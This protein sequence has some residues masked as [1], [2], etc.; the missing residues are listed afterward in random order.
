ME[1]TF[2]EWE[3]SFNCRFCGEVNGVEGTY[4]ICGPMCQP[5]LALNSEGNVLYPVEGGG[6]FIIFP[7]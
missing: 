7:T 5:L 4:L 2:F 6:M 3:G 1:G